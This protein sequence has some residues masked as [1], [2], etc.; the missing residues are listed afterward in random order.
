MSDE[1]LSDSRPDLLD[2]LLVEAVSRG[3]LSI[4]QAAEIGEYADALADA[5]DE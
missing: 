2:E 1:P 3:R 4:D 5:D